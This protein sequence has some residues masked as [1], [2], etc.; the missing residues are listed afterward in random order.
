MASACNSRSHSGK[1]CV[2]G[3]PNNVSCKNGQ[4]TEGV[5]IHN[6]PSAKKELERHTKWVRF[7]RKH[8]PRWKPSETSILCGCHFEESCFEQNR[9]TAASLGTRV[10]LKPGTV[11]TIDS[12]NIVPDQQVEKS[13]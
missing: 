7:V 8:Q 9:E 2:A 3:S 5:S 13:L 6:F 11:P 10:R 1:Y 4:H 12:T